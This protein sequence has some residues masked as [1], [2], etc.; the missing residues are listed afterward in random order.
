MNGR[1]TEGITGLVIV[2]DDNCTVII[3]DDNWTCYS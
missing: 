2:G 3:A 1:G